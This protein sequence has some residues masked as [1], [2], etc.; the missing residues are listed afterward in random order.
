[1]LVT[2]GSRGIFSLATSSWSEQD[3]V[4]IADPDLVVILTVLILKLVVQGSG[5]ACRSMERCCSVVRTVGDDVAIGEDG[6]AADAV[7]CSPVRGVFVGDSP[8]A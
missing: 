5:S 2:P 4:W 8:P 7:A 3:A 1:M 6:S